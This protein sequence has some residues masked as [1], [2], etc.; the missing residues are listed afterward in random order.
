MCYAD[1]NNRLRQKRNEKLK[2]RNEERKGPNEN[3]QASEHPL[4]G[5]SRSYR[6]QPP[7]K[8]M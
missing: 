4:P 6:L 2:T 8:W 5:D 1:I 7:E 3:H